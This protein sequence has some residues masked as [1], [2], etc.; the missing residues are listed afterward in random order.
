MRK[1]Y[2]IQVIDLHLLVDLFILKKYQLH[3]AYR[4]ATNNA[5]LFMMLFRQR[6]FK[7]ISVGNKFTEVT[8]IW[9]GMKDKT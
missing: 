6:D 1:I 2:P 9:Y 4:G 8:N 7:M 5:R 3:Q